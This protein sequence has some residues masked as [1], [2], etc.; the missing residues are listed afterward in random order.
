MLV[1]F[2]ID[3]KE[4]TPSLI[5]NWARFRLALLAIIILVVIVNDYDSAWNP[6]DE[7]ETPV[8]NLNLEPGITAGYQHLRTE[9]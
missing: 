3:C 1:S 4:T 8:A 7:V 5:A 9:I 6:G 2:G